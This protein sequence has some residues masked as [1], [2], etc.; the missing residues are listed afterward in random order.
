VIYPKSINQSQ[1][2]K[3]KEISQYIEEAKKFVPAMSPEFPIGSTVSL[4]I[5]PL[6]IKTADPMPM[7]RP[8]QLLAVGSVGI[9]M[10]CQPGNHWV[11]KF[12]RGAF[13]IDGKYLTAETGSTD[14]PT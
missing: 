6:Y 7:L 8:G 1:S 13:L 5:Q 14:T 10:A 4:A 9:V 2:G 12:D 11:V 3:N